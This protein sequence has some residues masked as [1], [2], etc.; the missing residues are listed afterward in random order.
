MPTAWGGA[1]LHF[2]HWGG[3]TSSQLDHAVDDPGDLEASQSTFCNLSE[4]YLWIRLVMNDPRLWKNRLPTSWT[5][6]EVLLVC[7][8]AM[9]IL[10]VHC[11]AQRLVQSYVFVQ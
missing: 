6:A 4:P 3:C 2:S 11:F 8:E 9:T 7:L 5:C 1:P 10:E